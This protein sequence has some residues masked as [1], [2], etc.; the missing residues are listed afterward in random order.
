MFNPFKDREM[1]GELHSSPIIRRYGNNPILTAENVPY[2]ATYVFNAGVARYRG[3]YY[4]APR[5]DLRNL[6][7]KPGEPNMRSIHTGFGVSDDGT[8]IEHIVFAGLF[9]GAAAV[10]TGRDKIFALI[11][12]Y[13][14]IEYISSRVGHIIRRKNRIV[15]VTADYAAG[16]QFAGKRFV[17]EWIKHSCYSCYCLCWENYDT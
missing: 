11:A 14:G 15:F 10:D 3:K 1:P 7:K 2:P 8:H 5:V 4:I 12:R 17:F 16:M 6:D 13:T 9:V